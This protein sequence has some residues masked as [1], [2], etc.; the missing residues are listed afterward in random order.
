[1]RGGKMI[2]LKKYQKSS[3][4]LV[5]GV[6]LLIV[7][8]QSFLPFLPLGYAGEIKEKRSGEIVL[9]FA[10]L[11]PPP[12]LFTRAFEWWA[13]EIGKR[14]QGG[15][16]IKVYSGG[17]LAREKSVIEAVRVGLAD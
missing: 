8:G 11:E 3:L 6:T 17:L 15:L 13:D 2:H 7:F 16:R 5:G 14:T 10:N 9:R 4:F 12:S 1:M